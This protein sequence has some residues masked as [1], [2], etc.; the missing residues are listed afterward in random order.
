MV[1]LVLGTNRVRKSLGLPLA[2]CLAAD[3]KF[4]LIRTK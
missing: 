2:D 3:P 1:S 4:S